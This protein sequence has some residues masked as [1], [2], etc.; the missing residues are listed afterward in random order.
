MELSGQAGR[1]RPAIADPEG[2]L[3]GAAADASER[4]LPDVLSRPGRGCSRD[5]LAAAAQGR[6]RAPARLGGRRAA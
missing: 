5:A 2:G 3:R 4:A 6:L 1:N